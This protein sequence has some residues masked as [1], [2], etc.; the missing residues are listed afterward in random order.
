MGEGE[1]MVL[2]RRDSKRESGGEGTRELVEWRDD[3]EIDKRQ[4]FLRVWRE[5]G[6]GS[7]R[8]K[9]SRTSVAIHDAGLW[10]LVVMLRVGSYECCC[11]I[12][13]HLCVL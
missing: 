8:F 1:V 5:P 12:S 7:Q 2:R 13:L 4:I 11:R 3:V 9:G 10:F 6:S